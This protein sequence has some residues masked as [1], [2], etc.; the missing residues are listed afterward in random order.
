MN[1]TLPKYPEMNRIEL[2]Y[3]SP[4][5]L[6]GQEIHWTEKRDGSQLRISLV[7]GQVKVATH[8]Q[9]EASEQFINYLKETQQYDNIVAL[10][11]D[12]NGYCDNPVADFNYGAVIFG[13]IL[14]KG[15]S[16]ARFELH[17]KHDF[18]VFDIYSQ[19]DSRFLSYTSVY[20]QCY[21]YGLPC[22]ECWAISQHLDINS[23]MLYRD[24]ILQV[25]KDKGRE[26]TV[27]KAYGIQKFAKEKLDTPK[28]E[29][30]HIEEG[31]PQ[32]PALPD[33]E[34]M[35]AIAKV[36]AE[37]GEDIKDKAKA[38]PIIAKYVSEEQD[39]HLCGKP[40]R[41]LFEYYID[42]IKGVII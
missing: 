32:Y 1:E 20:Q 25:A 35:G 17:D 22:V 14:V 31:T 29:R 30:I 39:K 28:V 26:G 40:N 19:K 3:P 13:E 15:K 9:D 6:L 33:S 18:V 42:Y 5:I 23:L 37:L 2:L 24:Q 8:H 4:A 27:L 36:H 34:V 16:P 7:D 10:L 21:H 11:K 38:M 41:K 12:T